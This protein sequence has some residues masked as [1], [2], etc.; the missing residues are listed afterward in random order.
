MVLHDFMTRWLLDDLLTS[1]QNSDDYDYF[2][3]LNHS[4]G[5]ASMVCLEKKIVTNSIHNVCECHELNMN[6]WSGMYG[7]PWKKICPHFLLIL[8]CGHLEW[9]L[10]RALREGYSTFNVKYMI[11][12]RDAYELVTSRIWTS[13]GTCMNETCDAYEWV[14][15]HI[16]MSHVTCMNESC[17]TY[18]WVTPHIRWVTRMNELCHTY[19]EWV[20]PHIQWVTRMNEL[21][22]T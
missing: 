5:V 21:C 2:P 19:Y 20:T 18:E 7:V 17:H 12:L 1:S 22:H 6:H 3:C 14:T 11:E 10:W 13:H 4:H 8:H 15:S 16:R 9:H